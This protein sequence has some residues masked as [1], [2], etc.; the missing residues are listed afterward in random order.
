M[1]GPFPIS[2]PTDEETQ[3]ELV[4]LPQNGRCG[5]ET[6]TPRAAGAQETWALEVDG[7]QEAET[8]EADGAQEAGALEADRTLETVTLIAGPFPTWLPSAEISKELSPPPQGY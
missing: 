1:A 8:L 3:K 6:W 5:L 7:A 2:L 4:S